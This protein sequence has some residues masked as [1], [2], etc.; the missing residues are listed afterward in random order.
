[1]HACK[2][3]LG[4]GSSEQCPAAALS[5]GS[6]CPPGTRAPNRAA[7]HRGNRKAATS[8]CSVATLMRAAMQKRCNQPVECWTSRFM[9]VC[10]RPSPCTCTLTFLLAHQPEGSAWC[11]LEN[12]R[13]GRSVRSRSSAHVSRPQAA[14]RR[15]HPRLPGRGERQAAA[16]PPAH[17]LL[18]LWNAAALWACWWPLLGR[19]PPLHLPLK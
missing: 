4:A 17:V 3:A 19:W 13:R 8:A 16:L 7:A 18:L 6:R 14:G 5:Y 15:A 2:T 11:A 10:L 12:R 1:M 9:C